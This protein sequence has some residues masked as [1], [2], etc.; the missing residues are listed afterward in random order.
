MADEYDET[1]DPLAEA[2]SLFQTPEGS[3]YAGEAAARINDYL[4]RR[5]IA[6]ANTAA[7][8]AFVANLGAVQGNLASMVQS[9]PHAIDLAL[10]L[11]DLS[12]RSMVG[13]VPNAD[14]AT[15]EPI[16]TDIQRGIARAGVRALAERHDGA[17]RELLGRERIA[18]LL[19]DEREAL[20]GY[21]S[22]QATAR[23]IDQVASERMAARAQ[24]Q[25]ADYHAWNYLGAMIDPA[26][27]DIRFPPGWAQRVMADPVIPAP[28]KAQLFDIYGKVER[29]GDVPASD[30]FSV[31]SLVF[32]LAQGASFSQGDIL[33]RA[34]D[35]LRLTD[36]LTLAKF[37]GDP[38]GR[39]QVAGLAT[40]LGE[41][42]RQLAAAENGPAGQ[43]AYGRFVNWLLPVVRRG[44][45]LDPASPDYVLGG[46]RL[47][48]FA[49]TAADMANIYIPPA[50]GDGRT[51]LGDIFGG[52]FRKEKFIDGRAPAP[53]DLGEGEVYASPAT[54][55]T[56]PEDTA[57]P[58]QGRDD[59][60]WNAMKAGSNSQEI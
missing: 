44:A 2:V 5:E 50:G 24:Q 31:S 36:A 39:S 46:N 17:A 20:D 19:G 59:P 30:P 60:L 7:G 11:A 48:A 28:Q 12:V 1:T 35:D 26:S 56:S 16:A 13:T 58:G 55:I 45:D 9:D 10:D 18:G 37:A 32:D 21:I 47:Q 41:A 52:S 25:Q 57:P 40:V 38:A 6:D 53:K 14:P 15:V 43:S 51:P 23:R 27:E 4:T 42:Q 8:D 49:P 33:G 3:A 54:G 22:A 29:D 34:G